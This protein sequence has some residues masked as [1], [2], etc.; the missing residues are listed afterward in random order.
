MNAVTIVRYV[1]AL[2]ALAPFVA[3]CTT[4]A[5][6]P[7]LESA[8]VDFRPRRMGVAADIAKKQRLLFIAGGPGVNIYSMPDLTLKGQVSLGNFRPQGECADAS[9]NVWVTTYATSTYQPNEL[10]KLAHDGTVLD[11]METKFGFPDSCAV[12]STTGNL[13]VSEN[14]QYSAGAV[15]VYAGGSGQG[16]PIGN[17]QQ[18]SYSWDGYDTSGDLWVDGKDYNG[19]FILSQCSAFSCTTIP[20]TGGRIFLGGFVQYGR[21][22]KTWYVADN[23]CGNVYGAFCIY[24]VS[25]SGALGTPIKLTNPEGQSVGIWQGVITNGRSRTL[26]GP[27]TYVKGQRLRV[28]IWNFPAGG[29]WTNATLGYGGGAAISEK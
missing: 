12:D 27:I 22:E 26:A 1:I 28:A 24:P 7:G 16:Q 15:L 9:G 5:S 25:R 20:I 8:H 13:A 23:M 6:S 14:R 10:V 3:A 29:R 11:A 18:Y 19:N 17:P 21:G 2:V 4:S